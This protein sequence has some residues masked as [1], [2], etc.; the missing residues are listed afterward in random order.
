MQ[1]M[2][3]D[4]TELLSK[5]DRL[6]SEGK[7][8]KN[9]VIE[10][11][12]KMDSD[13]I[14]LL[15]RSRPIKKHFF[16]DADGVLVFDKIKFQ[17]FVSN[18]EFLPDSY[19]AF[20]NKI[21]LV[22]ENGNY[23]SESKEVVLAWPY[24]DCVLEGGQTKED[25]KR[26]EIFWNETLAPDEIDRLL[27]PK[28]FTNFRRYDTHGERQLTGKEEL[29]FSKESLIVKGNN[30]LSLHSLYKPF[31]GKVKLIYI[32]PPYNTGDDSFL[33]NDK[34][35]HSTW[36]TFMKNR[37]EIAHELLCNMGFLLVQVDNKERSY[38]KACCDEVFGRDNFRNAIIVKKGTKSLQ[39]QFDEIVRLN[40]GYDTILLY[41]KSDQVKLPNLFKRLTGPKNSSWN[42]HW[43]GTDRPTMRF[44]LFG[45]E[46]ESG[47]WRWS[48]KRTMQ[49]TENFKILNEYMKARGLNANKI[50]D[51]D[52]DTYY[53]RY[54]QEHEILDYSDFELV[55]LSSKG[56]PEHYIPASG[57]I[58][59]SE[60]WMDIN[61]AGRVT[62]FAHEKNEEIIKRILEWLTKKGDIVLDFF[63]GTGTTSAVT[64][65]MGRQYIGIEQLDYGENDSLVRLRNVIKGDQSGISK[66][67]KWKGG[68]SFI[69]CELMKYNE[70]YIQRI[71]KAK[72]TADLLVI[73][74]S[75][76]EKAFISYKVE[77]KAINENTSDF[78]KLT[79]DEKKRLLIEIL[80]KNQLYVNYS[81]MDD[82]E[83]R[84][85]ETDKKLNRKF[86]EES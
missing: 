69:S 8:L 66:S 34:F 19:T 75:M 38:L 52:I 16:T 76:Q 26:D 68:G 14:K 3:R 35:N 82:A 54:L 85:S 53:L 56:K 47:Q 62:T 37:L 11:A 22:N 28:V 4:L 78:E 29:D 63:L 40:A 10:L 83:Y 77:P 46:P 6:V 79:I 50:S 58:L 12:L 20:K 70:T 61:V 44:P 21:G 9:K 2:L 64:H 36:L 5:D 74:K 45:I 42:N 31:A 65:K 60:N 23:L 49:A 72:T 25:Q 18:K 24:K 7:L 32:D 41:S 55:R 15:L 86:Y 80:D 27:A 57:E 48:Q 59:L 1:N 43:R 81:E 17:K 51:A 13:L 84:I 30:L 67:E 71:R 39:K 33:Y 73:W